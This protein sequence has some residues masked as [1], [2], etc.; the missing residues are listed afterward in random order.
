MG[1]NPWWK[2]TEADL[3]WDEPLPDVITLAPDYS[4]ELPLWGN[5]FGN[6]AW[7]YTKFSCGLLERL[8]AWQQEF[9]AHCHWD[10]GWDSD[11]IRNRWASQAEDLAADVRAELGTRAKLVVKPWARSLRE[12]SR[13]RRCVRSMARPVLPPVSGQDLARPPGAGC[14]PRPGTAEDDWSPHASRALWSCGLSPT[15]AVILKAAR[16]RAI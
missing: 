13:S 10:R 14:S 16:R 5:G 3:G 15:L 1:Q 9:D 12:R 11:E 4:A 8:A 7:Q 2:P 6:V